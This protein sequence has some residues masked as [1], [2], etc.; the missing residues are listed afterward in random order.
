MKGDTAMSEGKAVDLM[1]RKGLRAILKWIDPM[2][3]HLALEVLDGGDWRRLLVLMDNTQYLP[4]V[5]D[6]HVHLQ[7]LGM[8]EEALLEALIGTRTNHSWLPLKRIHWLMGIADREKLAEAGDPLP[9]GQS[10]VLYRGISGAPQ[11]RRP[12]GVNWTSDFKTAEWFAMRFTEFGLGN[13]AVVKATIKREWIYAYTDDRDE[14]E[15]I[16][17]VPQKTPYE[18]MPCKVSTPATA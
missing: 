9:N 1:G 14:R 10:Y 2:L 4:F 17:V 15:F 3:E 7:R 16:C 8:Y 18:L 12:L 11:K 6:C 13:P 5:N